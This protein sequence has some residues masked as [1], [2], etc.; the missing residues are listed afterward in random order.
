[1]FNL[2]THIGLSPYPQ[3]QYALCTSDYV[4]RAQPAIQ[5]ILFNVE[6]IFLYAKTHLNRLDLKIWSHYFLTHPNI[7]ANWQD[8]DVNLFLSFSPLIDLDE[9]KHEDFWN[10]FIDIESISTRID[11][12]EVFLD[13][14]RKALIVTHKSTGLQIK[15]DT[16]IFNSITT[17]VDYSSNSIKKFLTEWNHMFISVAKNLQ[18]DVYDKEKTFEILSKL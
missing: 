4:L 10:E 16:V 14:N 13:I 12:N 18:N 6:K 11:L 7:V 1:M 2:M 8:K 15:R 5:Q 3:E 9:C 17:S